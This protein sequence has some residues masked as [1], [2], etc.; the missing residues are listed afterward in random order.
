MN[1]YS[2][3]QKKKDEERDLILQKSGYKVKRFTNDEIIN[4]SSNL[5]RWL[6]GLYGATYGKRK[7]A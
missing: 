4:Y 2:Y 1:N 6:T 7:T 3:D 5:H